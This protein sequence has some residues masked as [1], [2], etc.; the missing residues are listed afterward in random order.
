MRREGGAEAEIE[1]TEKKEKKK[2]TNNSLRGSGVTVV[3]RR[4]LRL[5]LTRAPCDPAFEGLNMPRENVEIQLCFFALPS[6]H[7][8]FFF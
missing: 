7:P 3:D 1:E 2:R 6:P 4:E 5:V 8:P